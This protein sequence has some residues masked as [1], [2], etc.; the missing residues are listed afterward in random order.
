MFTNSQ[1]QILTILINQ[2]DREYYLSELGEII[3]KHPGVFQRGIISLENQGLVTSHKKG[4]QRLFRINK[5]HL[6]FNEVRGIIQKTQGTEGLL[7]KMVK[8]IQ[9]ITTALIYGSYPR[10]KMRADS[11]V[12]ILVVGDSK[13]EDALLHEIDKAERKLQREINYRFYSMQEFTEKIQ[14]KDPFLQEVLSDKYIL[15]KGKI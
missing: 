10:D 9:S 7:R 14:G 4:N 15:L 11:D 2:P 5:T 12:D 1:I 6:L 3:R 13:A 8:R